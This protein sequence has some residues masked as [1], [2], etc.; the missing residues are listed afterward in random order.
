MLVG[1]THMCGGSVCLVPLPSGCLGGHAPLPPPPPMIPPP[2]PRLLLPRSSGDHHRSLAEGGHDRPSG[3][4]HNSGHTQDGL[5][6]AQQVQEHRRTARAQRCSVRHS[7]STQTRAC[8]MPVMPAGHAGQACTACCSPPSHC[9]P[10]ASLS[11]PSSHCPSCRTPSPFLPVP[12]LPA[13][14]TPATS[15]EP[16]PH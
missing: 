11:L 13:P 16:P 15:P 3:H 1:A 14:P 8:C 9:P 7:P 10:P 6:P 5:H 2:P 4:H 12:P